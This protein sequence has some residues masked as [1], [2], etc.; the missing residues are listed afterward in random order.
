MVLHRAALELLLLE[1]TLVEEAS[2]TIKVPRTL[3]P[4]PEVV[5][6]DSIG[7]TD[8]GRDRLDNIPGERHVGSVL[9]QGV[10]CAYDRDEGETGEH[11]FDVGRFFGVFNMLGERLNGFFD[12]VQLLEERFSVDISIHAVL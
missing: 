8:T 4:Q 2:K 7:Q 12:K 3:G 5:A 9:G 11:R 6:A 10:L 1:L